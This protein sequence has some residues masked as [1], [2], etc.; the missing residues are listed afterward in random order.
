MKRTNIVCKNNEQDKENRL[1]FCIKNKER[2]WNYLLISDET[3]FY[4][5]LP[6]N[7]DGSHQVNHTKVQKQSSP[8][9]SY[10]G[11]FSS[12]VIIKLKFLLP[13]WIV[14]CTLKS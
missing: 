1:L 2:D 7:I 14:R 11:A 6:E 10:L 9:N 3:S 4:L 13:T 5:L 8:K 12:K